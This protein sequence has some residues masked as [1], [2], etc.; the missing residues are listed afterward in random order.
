MKEVT[1]T[2]KKEIKN[3]RREREHRGRGNEEGSRKRKHT[4]KD[5][6][7]CGLSGPL[8]IFCPNLICNK[9]VLEGVAFG[10]DWVTRSV[11]QVV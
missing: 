11:T 3:K 9:T 5:T 7:W 8:Q 2:R 10:D 6:D 1:T 4:K